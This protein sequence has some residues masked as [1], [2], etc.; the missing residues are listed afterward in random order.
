MGR[1][2]AFSDHLATVAC[3]TP[4]ALGGCA[5]APVEPADASGPVVNEKVVDGEFTAA[6]PEIGR[7]S[8]DGAACTATLVRRG[9]SRPPR[10]WPGRTRGGCVP[11]TRA[12]R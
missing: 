7:I 10:W 4:L 1:R 9:T 3:L 8:L 5:D 12:A 2:I 11:G 6:R